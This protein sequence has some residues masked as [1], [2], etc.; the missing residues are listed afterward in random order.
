MN[1]SKSSAATLSAATVDPEIKGIAPLE[2]EGDFL[3]F[4]AAYGIE[5]RTESHVVSLLHHQDRKVPGKTNNMVSVVRT[6]RDDGDQEVLASFSY[7]DW[8]AVAAFLA[9]KLGA[10][11]A[12]PQDLP[13][14]FK[15]QIKKDRVIMLQS[16]AREKDAKAVKVPAAEYAA[17]TAAK[18]AQ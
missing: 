16:L 14:D 7:R 11:V 13:E 18:A 2:I 8:L 17:L 3:T 4:C 6:S 5:V 9:S 12:T 10:V 15:P 1:A